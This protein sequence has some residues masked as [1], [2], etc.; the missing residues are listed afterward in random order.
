MNS[1][2]LVKIDDLIAPATR[3]GGMGCEDPVFLGFFGS[4]AQ[5]G[6]IPAGS[7]EVRQPND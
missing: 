7:I 5:E 4:G 1:H 2:G 6:Q 3:E